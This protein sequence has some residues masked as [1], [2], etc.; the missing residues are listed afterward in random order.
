M[1]DPVTLEVIYHRL[2]SIADEMETAVLKASMS[3]IVKEARDCTTAIFDAQG[4]IAAQAVV[5]PA[6]RSDCNR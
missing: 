4:R 5:L 2:T 3:T 1:I 6:Q